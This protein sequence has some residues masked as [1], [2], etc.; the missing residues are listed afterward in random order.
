MSWTTSSDDIRPRLAS[1]KSDQ[2]RAEILARHQRA[3]KSSSSATAWNATAPSSRYRTGCCQAPPLREKHQADRQGMLDA[4]QATVQQREVLVRQMEDQI[5]AAVEADRE[6]EDT[7]RRLEDERERAKR[8]VLVDEAKRALTAEQVDA[9]KKRLNEAQRLMEQQTDVERQRQTDLLAS[10][11]KERRARQQKKLEKA[12]GAPITGTTEEQLLKRH[13]VEERRL[14]AEAEKETEHVL[15]ETETNLQQQRTKLAREKQAALAVARSEEKDRIM[16][17]FDEQTKRL[18]EQAALERDKQ[19]RDMDEK[20]RARRDALHKRQEAER[21]R[22][23]ETL[24][25]DI[26]AD[27]ESAA[28]AL[29]TP[30]NALRLLSA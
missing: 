2:Q 10:K 24:K 30:T 18:E 28:A 23:L 3:L 6:L 4:S 9:V 11:L 20:R 22:V 7:R 16:A 15:Q 14:E 1:A 19:L 26:D 12:E 13:M 29:P 21:A 5:E 8:Q 17:D 27:I 25:E